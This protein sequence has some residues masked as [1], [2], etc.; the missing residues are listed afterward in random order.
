MTAAAAAS[1][2]TLDAS[3][4]GGW[5]SSRNLHHAI[6]ILWTKMFIHNSE[7]PYASLMLP[8]L[9]GRHIIS[10]YYHK[11]SCLRFKGACCTCQMGVEWERVR[12]D[13][14]VIVATCYNCIFCRDATWHHHWS[15]R[16]LADSV[17]FHT[18]R[19]R[20][21]ILS[22]CPGM[23]THLFNAAPALGEPYLQWWWPF[24][25]RLYEWVG[26][27]G[28]RVDALEHHQK[29]SVFF[30]WGDSENVSDAHTLQS[31]KANRRRE[32]R[33]VFDMVVWC[34]FGCWW[35]QRWDCS[36]RLFSPT[37]YSRSFCK[38][39]WKLWQQYQEK[40]M[41]FKLLEV[42]TLRFD[43]LKTR[44]RPSLQRGQQWGTPHGAVEHIRQPKDGQEC[45]DWDTPDGITSHVLL[46]S[47]PRA[48][49]LSL[50]DVP[51]GWDFHYADLVIDQ[52]SC[53]WRGAGW[54]WNDGIWGVPPSQGEIEAEK[55]DF[56][57]QCFEKG[58]TEDDSYNF[59]CIRPTLRSTFSLA[60][61]HCRFKGWISVTNF[62][63]HRKMKNL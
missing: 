37:A 12:K 28:V 16:V 13:L 63:R 24:I 2:P 43:R 22:S 15:C 39:T 35:W 6:G 14:H 10:Y 42:I 27:V 61:H 19:L 29:Q 5:R 33:E 9:W 8:F 62:T 47:S 3:C 59:C 23:P 7:A 51:G 1:G 55:M 41:S 58:M 36:F 50:H 45:P 52:I 38:V 49:G 26:A 20:P 32:A 54:H 17:L 60:F 31:E 44:H 56:I 34:R 21:S 40:R 11:M 30:I 46:E 48:Y 4:R 18:T 25:S 57:Q 53:F